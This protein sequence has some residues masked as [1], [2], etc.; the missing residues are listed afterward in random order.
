[1]SRQTNTVTTIEAQCGT[2]TWAS[3]L[4]NAVGV[5]AIH[6]DK[7]GHVVNVHVARTITYGDPSTPEAQIPGQLTIDDQET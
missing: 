3:E 6:H 7:T 5:A 4:P 1:M 2:C